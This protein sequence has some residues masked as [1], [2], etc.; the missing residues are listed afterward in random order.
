[1][2]RKYCIGCREDFYNDQG[3]MDGKGC[4]S[5]PTAEVVTRYKLG[6]WTAPTQPN[7]FTKVTTHSCHHAPG[8]YA[9]Y[10]ELPPF[11]KG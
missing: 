11:V 2:D 7:A 4:W 8:K 3:G 1:M 6:W 10:K 5:G 9:L